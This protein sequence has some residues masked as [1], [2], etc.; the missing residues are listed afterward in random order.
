MARIILIPLALILL[1]VV[2]AALLI[3]LFVDEDKILALAADTLQ[4]QTGATL[5]VNGDTSLSLFPVLGVSL[6]DAAITL[7]EKS[8][9]DARVRSLQIGVQILPLLSGRVE[10]D[11]FSLDGLSARIESEAEQKALDT[12]TLS[13]RELDNF[14]AQRRQSL[15]AAGEAAGTEFALAVP[16]ALNVNRLA[17]TDAEIELVDAQGSAPSIIKITSLRAS[18]LNL[19]GRAMPLAMA[20]QVKGDQAVDVHLKGDILFAQQEQIASLDKLAITI[21]GATAQ[22]LELL[23]SGPIDLPRR[24]AD[25]QLKLTTGATK[26]SGKL[27]YANFESP[28]ID[29]TLH[30]NLLDPALLALAGPEAAG[31]ADSS[32]G[33][34]DAPLPLDAIRTIDTRAVLTIDEVRSGGHTI[35][36]VQARLRAVDG[37]VRLEKLSGDLYGGQL[38]AR[39]TFNGK[40][41]TATLDTSGSVSNLDIAR[42]LAAAESEAQV[43]GKA[44]LHWQLRSR[45]R[46][47]N[48][49]TAALNGPIKL[50]TDAVELQGTSVEKTLCQA[51]ALTNKEKLTTVFPATTRFKTVAASIQLADG[52]AR[53][54]PLQAELNDVALT[55]NGKFNLM[56][57]EF[58]ATFKARLSP[59]LE[60]LDHACRVSKR[61][62]AIDWPVNCSGNV[63]TEPSNWCRVDTEQIITDLT[64]NEGKR[65]LEKEASK[66][67]NKLFKKSD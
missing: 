65:K 63:N 62:V 60:E 30:L 50:D 46:T 23:A 11:T 1:L 29:S 18:D 22:P 5:T 6:T 51:V 41:N 16:L 39:A 26:G 32:G 19:D 3:P 17:I 45:G 58:S 54:Q 49:L 13:D 47:A 43:R 52:K 37:V 14:Y 44:G 64:V 27:R 28:Q 40:H 8:R 24:I 15:A 10:I 2:A 25:L 48:E 56:T 33:D 57:E 34:G 9:P 59:G 35:E 38:D 21:A 36:N 67:L 42:T 7:P 53:L 4:E 66:L 61:L 20:L 55:G 12:S 31:A